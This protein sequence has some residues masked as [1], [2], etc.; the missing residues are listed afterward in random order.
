MVGVGTSQRLQQPQFGVA[1]Q[2]DAPTHHTHFLSRD[3]RTVVAEVHPT[4]HSA[5]NPQIL[6]PVVSHTSITQVGTAGHTSPSGM[7]AL[8]TD[9]LHLC[10]LTGTA[11]VTTAIAAATSAHPQHEVAAPTHAPPPLLCLPHTSNMTGPDK[12]GSQTTTQYKP[13]HSVCHP[14]TT[15][16][17]CC[18][19]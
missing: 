10:M 19:C 18:C 3:T 11:A 7:T 2:C 5:K 13:Q 12:K 17:C 1:R 8:K 9:S 14:D 6:N 15:A 16:G 4:T